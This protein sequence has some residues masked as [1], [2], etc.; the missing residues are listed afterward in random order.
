MVPINYKVNQAYQSP[1]KVWFQSVTRSVQ[2]LLPYF[3]TLHL[4]QLISHTCIH[5]KFQFLKLRVN[6]FLLMLR[7]WL[8]WKFAYT[9]TILISN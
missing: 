2:C 3:S 4:V 6:I 9:Q 5:F 8:N 1:I 7:K